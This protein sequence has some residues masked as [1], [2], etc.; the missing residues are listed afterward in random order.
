[1]SS[2]ANAGTHNH[3]RQL[4]TK[5]GYPI[6][7]TH[8]PRRMGPRVRGDDSWIKFSRYSITRKTLIHL[9][10]RVDAPQPL[11]FD[12]AIKAVAGNMAPA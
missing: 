2:P 7:L 4:F 6:A 9:L 10:I 11:L 8:G 5:A 1:M 12:P 3:H